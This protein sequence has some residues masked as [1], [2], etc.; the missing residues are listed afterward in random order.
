[1]PGVAQE[2]GVGDLRT[3]GHISHFQDEV[4]NL[5]KAASSHRIKGVQHDIALPDDFA[6]LPHVVVLWHSRQDSSL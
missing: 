4:G 1:V 3:Y 6:D 2:H 5:G